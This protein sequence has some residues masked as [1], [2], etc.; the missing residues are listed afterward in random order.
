MLKAHTDSLFRLD[1]AARIIIM[2]DLNDEPS[3]TSIARVLGAREVPAKSYKTAGLYNVMYPR[4]RNGE[5]TLFYKD[6]DLFDQFIVS[7]SLLKK[8]RGRAASIA[9]PY[10]WIFKAPWLLYKNRSGEYVPNRT[11]GSRDYF[12]GYSDHLPVY[13][14]LNL[15]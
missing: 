12:G 1:P 15:R 2:G 7:G 6:W 13:L 14:R 3:D 9:D 5:G 11:A 8:S 10:A 4:F